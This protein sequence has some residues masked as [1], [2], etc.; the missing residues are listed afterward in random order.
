MVLCGKSNLKALTVSSMTMMAMRFKSLAVFCG[1]LLVGAG[2]NPGVDARAVSV[3]A[4]W[5]SNNIE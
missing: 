4:S 3:Q 1:L 2:V 5:V